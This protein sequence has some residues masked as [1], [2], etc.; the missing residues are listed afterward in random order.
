M[1]EEQ[2][3]AL[4]A[5]RLAQQQGTAAESQRLVE[6]RSVNTDVQSVVDLRAE[7]EQAADRA[8]VRAD[9][10]A[11]EQARQEQLEL[12]RQ[13]RAFESQVEG[14]VFGTG[15]EAP[16]VQDIAARQREAA[17]QQRL[18]EDRQRREQIESAGTNTNEAPAAEISDTLVARAETD[19]VGG[20]VQQAPQQSISD[21][22]LQSVY[23]QFIQ[24]KDAIEAR[25]I[26]AVLRLTVPSGIRIQQ[27]MQ[28]FENNVSISARLRNVSTL[29]AAGEIQ[30]VLQI[31]RLERLDGSVTGPS[32]DL[33]S[34][35]L[36]AVRDSNGWSSIRW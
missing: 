15:L 11:Q 7:Q 26:D 3:A 12:A 16:T 10:Q 21:A 2:R 27:V 13:E 25:D 9:R 4:E 33:G 5:Q 1:A 34:V 32:L 8:Q 24:L 6:E 19:T 30:G 36:S 29:D 17:R 14:A 18:L 35:R 22:D 23:G 20:L 31:T 28:M